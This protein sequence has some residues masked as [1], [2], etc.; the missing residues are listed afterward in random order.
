MTLTM[1]LN[2][3]LEDKYS[4]KIYQEVTQKIENGFQQERRFY[5]LP[6]LPEKFRDRVVYFPYI[7]SY[8]NNIKKFNE[9]INFEDIPSEVQ[10]DISNAYQPYKLSYNQKFLSLTE[11]SKSVLKEFEVFCSKNDLN[12][13]VTIQACPVFV[14]SLGHYDMNDGTIFIHPRFDRNITEIFGLILTVLVHLKVIPAKNKIKWDKTYKEKWW[15]KQE[16]TQKLFNSKEYREIFV[17]TKDTIE[18]LE[19][20]T[21][22]GLAIESIE[23]LNKLNFPI[24]PFI[25][26][27]EQVQTLTNQE[28]KILELLI[29]NRG[30]IV[31]YNQ[32]AEIMWEENTEEKFSLYAISK[33][34]ERVRNKIQSSGIKPN[35]IHSQRGVGY[36]LYD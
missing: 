31:D 13:N 16:I 6:Y 36:V 9:L 4:V 28:K 23:Y 11:Q 33:I 19:D 34:I 24:K 22:G 12:P 20:N 35:L 27:A 10:K 14:G 8:L 26:N 3:V 30:A 18:V 2:W 5:I 25:K 1:K 32:I 15:E 29:A 21:A 7:E 17:N